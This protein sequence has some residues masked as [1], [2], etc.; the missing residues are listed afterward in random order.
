MINLGTVDPGSTIEIPFES[1]ASSS[2]APITI[3]GLATSDIKVYKD[4]GTTERASASGYTLLDTDGIDFDGITGIHGFSI[5]LADNTTADFW[6]AGSRYIVVVS[7]ITVDSQ[8]MSFIAA[9]FRI[10]KSGAIL[11]TTIATLA[12]QTSFTL[13]SGP[14]EDDALNGHW[15][16]IHDAAS[17]VQFAPV[18]I[19]DYTGSTKTVTLAAGATF[20]VAAK[21]NISIM[22]MVPLQASTIGRTL[23]VDANSKAP[24]TLAAGDLANDSLTAAALKQDLTDE[25]IARLLA[26]TVPAGSPGEFGNTLIAAAVYAVQAASDAAPTKTQTTAGAIAA[27]VWNALTSGLTTVGS[28]GKLLVDR[29]DAAM[30]SRAAPGDAM[31]LTSGERSTLTTGIEAELANDATGEALKQAIVDKIIE[32]LPSLDDLTLAAIAAAVRDVS[33]A[34]PAANS[35]GAD[36]AAAK[37]SAATAATQATAG[38]TSAATAATQSTTAATQATTAAT[39]STTAATQSTAAASSSAAVKVVTDKLATGIELDG[40]VYRFTANALEQAPAG[41]GGGGGGDA[42]LANQEIIIESLN[43]LNEAGGV[44]MSSPVA[45]TGLLTLVRGDDYYS[46]DGAALEWTSTEWP[47]LTGA[48]IRFSLQRRSTGT[49]AIDRFEGSVVTPTGTAKVR[50]ELTAA[51]TD[52]LA[53]GKNLYIYDVEATLDGGNIRTLVH[54]Q[55]DVIRDSTRP[56]V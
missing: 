6:A 12:S 47:D 20:T 10:G 34:S 49:N 41:G 44:V 5:S 30:T 39:Q 11:D 15:A 48:T 16:I 21:D 45:T 32:N 52:D 55:C 19:L 51:Q 38:A 33:N 36:L 46:A 4:G 14:A 8:T 53:P 26:T 56:A 22:G 1:F 2:G 3:T 37:S 9:T 28:I 17:A 18:M 29:I 13:T 50:V 7:T 43:A 40:A 27:A 24:A 23:A 31:A 25:I 35:L 42:T 54:G